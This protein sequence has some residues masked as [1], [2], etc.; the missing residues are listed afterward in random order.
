MK[1]TLLV[2]RHETI[3]I[4]T[5]PSFLFAIFGVPLL[6]TLVFII[7]GL[8]SKG[9]SST[10]ILA[11]LISSP[12]SVQTEG[13]VDQ[14][15]LIKE[16]PDSVQPGLLVAFPDEESARQALD[17]AEIAAYYLIS[18]DYIDSGKVS[19]VSAEVNPLSA[20]EKSKLLEWIINVNL[21]GGDTHLAT[22][23]NGPVNVQKVSLS[24]APQRDENNMLTYWLPYGVTMLFYIVILS[25]ASLLLSSVAKE[26]ENRVMEILM[27]SLTPRQLLTGKIVGLGLIGLLQTITWVG[28]GR[29]LLARGGTTFNLSAAFQLPT[30][31][32]IWGLLFFVLGYAVYA[33]LM[34]GLGSMVPNLR[35]ASQATLMVIFP[36]IIP[37]F[38][39]N[40]LIEEPHG[41]LSTILSLFPLTSPVAMMTRISAGDVP[42]WQILLAAILLILTAMLVVRAVARMFQAQSILSGQPFSRKV[43]FNALLGKS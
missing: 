41:L 33:S 2:L 37:I 19:Y 30:S 36:L 9:T 13:Y 14:S 40:V 26:K 24:T 17:N 6:G 16:I 29:L 5:R 15:G 4:L 31:F 3:T 12:P 22:L 43:F 34:A 39:I 18:A 8:L 1:K 11:Q 38:L 23:V 20:S 7:A 25:A 21:L 28:T 27:L 42:I 35:E 32:L 10:N